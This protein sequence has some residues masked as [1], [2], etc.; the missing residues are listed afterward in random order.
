MM[1]IL[2]EDGIPSDKLVRKVSSGLDR[3]RRSEYVLGRQRRSGRADYEIASR[4]RG[5]ST[6]SG[7]RVCSW[8]GGDR[9]G[10]RRATSKCVPRKR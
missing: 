1:K 4:V 9:T 7:M 5:R 2:A 6:R 10:R 3:L 8:T